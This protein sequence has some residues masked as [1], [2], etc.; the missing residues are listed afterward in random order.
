[1]ELESDERKRQ[2]TLDKRGLDFADALYFDPA[3][4]RIYRDSRRD[5]GEPR[6]NIYGYL[7]SVLCT[8]CWTPR[9]VRVRIIS[10]RKANDRE[11]ERYEEGKDPRYA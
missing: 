3:S 11:R 6:F 4:V 10:M 1:M 5:Y 2:W 8:F 9:E 7:D